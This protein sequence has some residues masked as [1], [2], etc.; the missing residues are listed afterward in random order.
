M[1]PTVS[2][3][4]AATTCARSRWECHNFDIVEEILVKLCH[5]RRPFRIVEI[6]FTFEKRKEGRTKRDLVRFALAISARFINCS[7]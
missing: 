1:S 6:P 2:G 7:A 4:I 3:S 5:L